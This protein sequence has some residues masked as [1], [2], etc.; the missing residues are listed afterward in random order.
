MSAS[1]PSGPLVFYDILDAYKKRLGEKFL[2]RIKNIYVF[3]RT[4]HLK[5]SF[6]RLHVYASLKFEQLIIQSK[7]L[8]LRI[9][10]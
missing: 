3:I 5:V 8:V 10:I 7:T 2:L 6:L 9:L 1:G 4:M